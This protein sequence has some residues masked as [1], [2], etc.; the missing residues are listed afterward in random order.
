MQKKKKIA[1]AKQLRTASCTEQ[2][3]DFIKV[4]LE[5]KMSSIEIAQITG[6]PHNDVMKA[7]RKMEP[8]WA[9]VCQ[10][11][12]SLTSRMVKMPNGGVREIPCYQLN[13]FECLYIA[14]KFND[15]ARARLVLRWAELEAFV[16]E[17]TRI[18]M[19]KAEEKVRIHDEVMK[20]VDS[21]TVRS[22]AHT[23][24]VSAQEL[25]RFLVEQK[26]Q[27]GQSGSYVPYVDFARK[28]FSKTRTYVRHLND[29][30]VRTEHRTTWMEP[31]VVF[32]VELFKKE[33]RKALPKP[34]FIQL[35][36]Q[37]I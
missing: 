20:S 24:G 28:N 4:G 19:E 36:F 23:L 35:T 16:A 7:I 10:G 6:K 18:E 15:E 29:G 17:Q 2:I 26:V 25:N 13:K 34:R 33:H 3:P 22:I 21:F 8:A 1:G 37:F 11:N 9:K 30:T 27:Y 5:Q 14:T 32:I 31:A 12:F